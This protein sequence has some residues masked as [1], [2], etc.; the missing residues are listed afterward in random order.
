ME[1]KPHTLKNQQV[2]KEIKREIK[3]FQ[4]QMTMENDNSKPVGCS[5]SSPK[6]EVY[7]NTILAQE[8]RKTP[9]RQPKFTPKILEKEQQ[10]QKKLVKGKKS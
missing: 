8:T 2:T 4:K 1:I 10:Q 5:K 3:N 6:G 7:S 9:N